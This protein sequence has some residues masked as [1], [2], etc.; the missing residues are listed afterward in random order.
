MP[1]GGS[2]VQTKMCPLSLNIFSSDAQHSISSST[3]GQN[4]HPIPHKQAKHSQF[5]TT[6]VIT[7]YLFS[8]QNMSKPLPFTA[9]EHYI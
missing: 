5:E 2:G 8:D 7:I 4:V 3:N 6:M 9:R 1:E